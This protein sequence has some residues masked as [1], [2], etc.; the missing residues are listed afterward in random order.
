MV[1]RQSSK[2]HYKN[3]Q[4]NDALILERIFEQPQQTSVTK[5][6]EGLSLTRQD[7]YNHYKSREEAIE[8]FTNSAVRG[9]VDYFNMVSPAKTPAENTRLFRR[10]LFFPCKTRRQGLLLHSH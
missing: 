7:F 3:Y 1:Q 10:L 9:L 8:K 4:K 6:M 2:T 5:L